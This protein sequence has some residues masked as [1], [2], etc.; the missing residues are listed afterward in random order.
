MVP[1]D[2]EDNRKSDR[3]RWEWRSQDRCCDTRAGSILR[4]RRRYGLDAGAKQ[5]HI[6][7]TQ[8]KQLWRSALHLLCTRACHHGPCGLGSRDCKWSPAPCRPGTA[9]SHHSSPTFAHLPHSHRL[10]VQQLRMQKSR[11]SL[12]AALLLLSLRKKC[13]KALK[14][15]VAGE[16]LLMLKLAIF[17]Y[18]GKF[19][20]LIIWINTIT[21]F[22]LFT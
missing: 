9:C 14:I 16:H 22:S 4:S 19:L 6:S 11:N 12:V 15:Q 2:D 1:F 5:C 18:W 7:I 3:S 8:T 21:I 10:L 20:G 13:R 17:G